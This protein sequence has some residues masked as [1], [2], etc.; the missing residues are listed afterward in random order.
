MKGG[1]F[2][3][4]TII[5][6][7]LIFYLMFILPEQKKQK[8]MKQ[9]LKALSVGDKIITRGG[10]IGVISKINEETLIISTGEPAVGITISRGAIGS[11]I[12]YAA[13][14]TSDE[15][16]EEVP[17]ESTPKEEETTTEEK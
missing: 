7:F 8:K 10:I 3:Y 4:I 17:A 5:A 9:M 14:N 11:V 1:G 16:N 6:I 15:K 2:N 12:E 13:S